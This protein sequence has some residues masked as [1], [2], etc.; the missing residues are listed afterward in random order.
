M[1]KRKKAGRKKTQ[2][3][4]YRL[5]IGAL[6]DDVAHRAVQME[7]TTERFRSANRKALIALL[8]AKHKVDERMSATLSL[9]GKMEIGAPPREWDRRID[10]V[11]ARM[12]SPGGMHGKS[13]WGP[14]SSELLRAEGIISRRKGGT[15]PPPKKKSKKGG[16]GTPRKPRKERR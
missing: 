11:L 16:F 4:Q 15:V 12:H 10:A 14:K 2:D 5:K 9:H 13:A 7:S 3:P 1:A 6:E 8:K